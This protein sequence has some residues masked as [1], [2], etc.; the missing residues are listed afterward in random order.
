MVLEARWGA[1]K[2]YRVADQSKGLLPAAGWNVEGSR[3]SGSGLLKVNSGLGLRGGCHTLTSYLAFY[4]FFESS[5]FHQ[6]F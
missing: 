6:H 4:L 2:A 3:M 1:R 5:A